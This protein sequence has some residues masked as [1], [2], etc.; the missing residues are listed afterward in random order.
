V[1][2]NEPAVYASDVW[3]FGCILFQMVTGK[4]PFRAAT[5][6]LTFQKILKL[7]YELPDDIDPDAKSLI[8]GVLVRTRRWPGRR[9]T[10]Q[11]RDP[12]QR[13]TPA[14]IKSHPFF[15]PIDFASLWS[16]PAP[17]ISTG[18]AK[19]VQTLATAGHDAELWAVFD[20]EV[21]DGGFEFDEDDPAGPR[22]PLARDH[23]NEPRF[24]RYAA[25]EAVQFVDDPRPAT[26]S[27]DSLE[28]PRP[29]FAEGQKKRRK[30]SAGSK[31]ARTSS[32]SSNNRTA[33]SGLLETMG[34]GSTPGT[35][36]TTVSG[37][38]PKGSVRT[39]TSRTSDRSD[40]Q[41]AGGTDNDTRL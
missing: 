29:G 3:A 12:A 38:T 31:S 40:E 5:D 18:I 20:D 27:T 14:E 21:S 8:E 10:L 13:L 33:L 23:S 36:P 22:S 41:K 39:R 34:L 9:L 15:A 24:D 17:T 30:W 6:Y 4:P 35:P 28:P 37:G 2:R 25:A 7:S 26:G 19:P 11:H 16:S 32:S 1:L